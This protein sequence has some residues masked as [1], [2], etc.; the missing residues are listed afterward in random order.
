MGHGGPLCEVA[1][2][3]GEAQSRGYFWA[4][5][6]ISSS[7]LDAKL[8]QPTQV[9]RNNT[10]AL[11]CLYL[12]VSQVTIAM[13]MPPPATCEET[14]MPQQSH[15]SRCFSRKIQEISSW[16]PGCATAPLFLQPVQ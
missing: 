11:A 12:S 1:C 5:L 10:A 2:A 3:K 13:A 7:G 16:I 9:K 6:W 14:A 4:L 15:P 8:S